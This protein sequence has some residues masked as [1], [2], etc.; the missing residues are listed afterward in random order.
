MPRTEFQILYAPQSFVAERDSWRTVILLNLVKSVRKVLD[1][2]ST[3]EESFSDDSGDID[4]A[5]ANNA[6]R[7]QGQ[8]NDFQADRARAATPI[9]FDAP[10]GPDDG[11]HSSDD[12]YAQYAAIKLR[13]SPLAVAEELLIRRLAGPD[14]EDEATNLGAWSPAGT[15]N[16]PATGTRIKE[17]FVRSST[18][19]KKGIFSSKKN[20]TQ[21]SKS[22]SSSGNSKHADDPIAL[23]QACRD[24]MITLWKDP[25][26]Q[27]TLRRKGI[28]MEESPGL[29]V[30]LSSAQRVSLTCSLQLPERH[31]SHHR[32]T[33]FSF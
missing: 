10:T 8:A 20:E 28:R 25:T 23:V 31:C 14:G 17:V 27:A 32:Q 4:N 26:V 6:R 12:T 7:R 13:L 9:T 29:Y 1:A 24:D 5:V 16:T 18:N 19:W 11:R 30:A 15:G 2:I 22:S 21:S 3:E 33:L